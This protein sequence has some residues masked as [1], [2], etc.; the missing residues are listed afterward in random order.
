[1][2][3]FFISAIILGALLYFG[4]QFRDYAN[5]KLKEGSSEKSSRYAPGKLPGLPA[6]L[7]ASWEDAKRKGPDGIREWFR[8]HRSQVSDPRLTEMELDYVVLAGRGNPAEARRVL[9]AIKPR[10]SPESP[11]YRRF[12]QLDQAYP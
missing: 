9:N 10:I 1:M 8:A 3:K 6:E 5:Q 4:L 2:L 11:Q 7:E 12:Q